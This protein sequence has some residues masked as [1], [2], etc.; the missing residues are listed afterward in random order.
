MSVFSCVWCRRA[1]CSLQKLCWV[2]LE[3]ENFQQIQCSAWRLFMVT[4]RLLNVVECYTCC[5]N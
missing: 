5:L 1:R 2:Q 4:R 3:L